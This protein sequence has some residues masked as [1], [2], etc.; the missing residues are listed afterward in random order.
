[1]FVSRCVRATLVCEWL[2]ARTRCFLFYVAQKN[3]TCVTHVTY[4]RGLA[5][6]RPVSS[7]SSPNKTRHVSCMSCTCTTIFWNKCPRPLLLSVHALNLTRYVRKALTYVKKPI[8]YMVLPTRIMF[9][10]YVSGQTHTYLCLI[11]DMCVS[12][13]TC[14]CIT[15]HIS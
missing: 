2:G 5:R 6:A 15:R 12:H 9:V 1:M 10:R 3:T 13:V 7:F 8:P 4:M 11:P 14:A